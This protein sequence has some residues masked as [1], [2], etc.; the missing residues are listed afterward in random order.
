MGISGGV[1]S[2]VSAALLKKQGYEVVGVFI[3]TWH[4]D[5]L[6]CNEE[7]ER[8]DAMRVAAYLD[9]PFLTFDFED[10]Y[11]KEVADYMIREYKMGRTPNPDVMCNK[12]VKFGV[13]L[14]KALSM[15]A[16]FVATGHYA[17]IASVKNFSRIPPAEGWNLPVK[18]LTKLLVK[19][20]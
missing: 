6:V 20:H 14:K 1:D 2:A 4:P 9:I 5:F 13:F 10:V 19:R 15:G 7:E 16:D 17:Q 11:K 3:K 8:R 18:I 12:E